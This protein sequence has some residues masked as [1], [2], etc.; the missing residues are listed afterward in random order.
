MKHYVSQQYRNRFCRTVIFLSLWIT[1]AVF[2]QS[3][4]QNIRSDYL[5]AHKYCM[6]QDWENAIM[7]YNS[8]IQNDPQGE[9]ADDAHFWLAYCQ[10]KIPGQQEAAFQNYQLL[11][12][13]FPDSKWADDAAVNQIALA[14]ALARSGKKEYR[15]FLEDMLIHA[16][17]DI[18]HMAALSLGRLGDQQ[19]LPILQEMVE[20]DI[21]AEMAM[22]LIES[23]ETRKQPKKFMASQRMDVAESN[24]AEPDRA[25]SAIVPS[26]KGISFESRRYEQYRAMLKSDEN[27]DFDE[28]V[29]FGMWHILPPKLFDEYFGLTSREARRKWLDDYWQQHDPTPGTARNE[30][31]EAFEERVRYA[32]SHFN[33]HWNLN[34]S[35]YLQDQYLREGKPHAPWDARGELYIKFGEPDYRVNIAW[36]TENWQYY[37]HNLDLLVK[38]Y[39]TNIYGN[40]ISATSLASRQIGN[41][42]SGQLDRD[43]LEAQFIYTPM[44]DYAGDS[45]WQKIKNVEFEQ[46]VNANTVVIAYRIPENEFGKT[47]AATFRRSYTI[48]DANSQQIASFSETVGGNQLLFSDGKYSDTLQVTLQP[49]KYQLILTLEIPTEKKRNKYQFDIEIGR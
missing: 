27:W 4:L 3:S 34:E 35:K 6:A 24:A 28:L 10:E 42:V 7:L 9:Y 20:N 16:N 23:L 40:A 5:Q 36:H 39:M 29:D 46:S 18:R 13:N 38:Q 45:D 11:R 41:R 32:H 48:F 12:Q 33:D 15:K 26:Q 47:G 49:G 43:R 14:E 1:A 8:I 44:F 37:R 2:A 30:A 25:P 21:Y 17:R 19:A 22:S 31:R